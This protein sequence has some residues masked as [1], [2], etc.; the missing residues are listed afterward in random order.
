[1]KKE[2]IKKLLDIEA[3]KINTDELYT[4]SSGIKSEMGLDN[5]FS[6]A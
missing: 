4:F 3:L 5:D 6:G 2:L 1:M